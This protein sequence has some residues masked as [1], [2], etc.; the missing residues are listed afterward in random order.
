MFVDNSG[1]DIVLGIMPFVR[2]LLKEKTRV[3]L[4]A[5]SE[6]ALN[7]VTCAELKDIV[8]EC[9]KICDKIA[10]AYS[11]Q[12]LVV[13]ANGQTGPCLDMRSLPPGEDENRSA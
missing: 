6:P 9:C 2:Q 1:C 4:C 12:E 13:Y 11:Q 3:I 7:D 10:A 8:Q 5:N